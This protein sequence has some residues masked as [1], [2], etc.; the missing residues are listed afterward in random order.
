MFKKENPLTSIIMN[1]HNGEKFLYESIN[2]VLNQTYNNWELIFY[3]NFSNDKSVAIASS[4]NDKRIKIYRSNS[5]LNLYHARNEAIKKINGK[6]ICFLDTDDFWTKD[7]IQQQIEFL[8]TNKQYSMVY[9]NFFL[10]NEKKKHK[11]IYFNFF[12]P[13]GRITKK[14]LKKYTIGILT[15]CIKS[16]IFKS[17]KFN[18]KLNIIG[19][20]DFFVKLSTTLNIGSIQAPLAFYREHESNY[21]KKNIK[22]HIEELKEWIE[23]NELKF[24][25]L[26]LSFYY[27]K[28][29]LFKL[30]IKYL[31]F[32]L[33]V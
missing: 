11:R 16:E 18:E 3:D 4:F 31:L 23:N 1:C 25:N 8:E 13:N 32:K 10:F 14:I 2:S 6:Y 24:K 27:Q 19:D 29:L 9:S 7:K 30:K 28:L 20:F 21:S 17:A 22:I 33:G 5:F 12:L 15:T 26:G